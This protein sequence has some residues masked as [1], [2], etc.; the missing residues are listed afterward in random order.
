[1]SGTQTID[2]SGT[3]SPILTADLTY[4]ITDNPAAPTVAVSV[5]MTGALSIGI[6][7]TIS[8]SDATFI[9]NSGAFVGA[10]DTLSIGQSGTYEQGGVLNVGALADVAFGSDGTLGGDFILESGLSLSLL[11]EITGFTHYD[12]FD[13][14]GVGAPQS[15]TSYS[16]TYNSTFLQ[17]DF[18][19]TLSGGG[20]SDFAL[21]GN[22]TSNSF[23][24]LADGAGGFKLADAPC[25]AAGTK[26]LTD[27]GEVSVEALRV[28]DTAILHDGSTARIVFIGYRSVDLHNHPRP[29]TVRPVRILAGSIAPGSPA[30]DLLISPDHALYLDGALVPAKHLIDGVSIKQD[31]T[32]R[33]IRYFHVEL[34]THGILIA[35]GAP[36]ESFL[37]VGH[38]GL[39]DNADEPIMLQTATMHAARETQS[40]APLVT[41][42]VALAAIRARLYARLTAQGFSVSK[43]ATLNLRFP[44][45]ASAAADIFDDKAVFAIPTGATTAVLSSA[46]FAPAEVD[47]ASD[48]RRCLGIALAGVTIDGAAPPESLLNP[49]DLHPCDA[50]EFVAWTRGDVRIALPPG[51]KNIAFDIAGWPQLWDKISRAA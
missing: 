36:A 38:R 18:F 27:A 42:G 39:F 23:S 33:A 6:N 29:E 32:L 7:D 20:T 22:L 24:L 40:C 41:G 46:V 47:P 44:D 37:N 45:G 11:S 9:N 19:V 4:I 17:T 21:Q 2:T 30:R 51:A 43:N 48:D 14:Q 10:F 5:T 31:L 12:T 34:E 8:I 28:G 35:N 26:I 16:D 13:L 50:G 49:D 25:F 3:F 15:A 1:M